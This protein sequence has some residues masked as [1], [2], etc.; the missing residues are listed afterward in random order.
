M[1]ENEICGTKDP[2][3]HRLL[4]DTRFELPLGSAFHPNRIPLAWCFILHLSSSSL[5]RG[6]HIIT[7]TAASTTLILR[8]EFKSSFITSGNRNELTASVSVSCVEQTNLLTVFFPADIPEE[9]ARYWAKKLEQLN[10][11]RDQ[12]VRSMPIPLSTISD[13]Y[14]LIYLPL[15]LYCI[16][17]PLHLFLNLAYALW[18]SAASNSRIAKV[19][20]SSQ[21]KSWMLFSESSKSGL[22]PP[23]YAYQEEQERPLHAP[24]TQCCE[25]QTPPLCPPP[26]PTPPLLCPFHASSPLSPSSPPPLRQGETGGRNEADR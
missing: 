23:Q 26:S 21:L 18:L 22:F 10:A 9:E 12:D 2:T 6:A 4:L 3:F 1:A 19:N 8:P 11:M 7:S 25:C 13:S 5:S 20:I 15:S 16:S 17:F 24:S 14:F